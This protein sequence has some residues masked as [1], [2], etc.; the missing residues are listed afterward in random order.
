MDS[1]GFHWQHSLLVCSMAKKCAKLACKE[2]KLFSGPG[3]FLL[4]LNGWSPSP[5]HLVF[6]GKVVSFFLCNKY[7]TSLLYH[8][9][10]IGFRSVAWFCW[11]FHKVQDPILI[12][13]ALSVSSII[14]VP[15]I[16]V[17]YHRG[18]GWMDE[19]PLQLEW[20]IM[21]YKCKRSLHIYPKVSQYLEDL[22]QIL[23]SRT[24]CQF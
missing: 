1:S 17:L 19:W 4:H 23:I 12:T 13:F 10:T 15:S 3:I 8:I 16:T 7:Y 11:K 22:W 5:F 21:S 20:G 6:L 9:L 2:C 18:H 24:R 14:P